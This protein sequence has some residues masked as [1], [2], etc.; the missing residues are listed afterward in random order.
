[1]KTFDDAIREQIRFFVLIDPPQ[2][3]TREELLKLVKCFPKA[4]LAE[5]DKSRSVAQ[6]G[7]QMKPM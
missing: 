1:M 7:L 4:N 2:R 3:C 5:T 6:A